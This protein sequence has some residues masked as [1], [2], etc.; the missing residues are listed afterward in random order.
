[1]TFRLVLPGLLAAA[2]AYAPPAA[3]RH[4]RDH[5]E[6]SLDSD[7]P[8]SLRYSLTPWLRAGVDLEVDVEY[9]QDL[10]LDASV[11]DDLGSIEPILSLA[12]SF[13]DGGPL[14][15]FIE[16]ELKRR[17]LIDPPDG[18]RRPP[19]RLDLKTAYLYASTPGSPLA[20][21]IGRQN[22]S[23]EREWLY[24][25]D[26]DGVRVFWSGGRFALE[27]SV[28]R[29]RLVD[30]DLL[31]AQS[32]ER[33]NNYFLVGRYAVQEDLEASAYVLARDDREVRPEDLILFG[34]RSYGELASD[35]D[36]WL[37][38]AIVRG[39]RRSRDIRGYGFDVGATYRIARTMR[40]SATLGLAFGSGD[41]NRRDGVD[42]DFRQ[43]GL[44]DNNARFNGVTS[45]GYYGE[46]L[47]PELSN[48]YIATAAFGFR[49]T[50]RSSIDLVYHYYRQHHAEDDLRDTALEVDPNGDDPHLG[51]ALDLVV[52]YREIEDMKLEL[53][54][55]A[56]F[57]GNA[58]ARDAD[59][60][61][62]G[63]FEVK[64]EL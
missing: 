6:I 41:Q 16:F 2:L 36:H 50:P 21:E 40:P 58:F 55:G 39:K 7:A 35:L 56:F 10:D 59:T 3:A 63:A 46:V 60:A 19:T 31:N 64:Y 51:Q 14:R 45:F 23:D 49:P 15:A 4:S 22:F 48:L 29:E 5:T 62:F 47:D 13:D 32:N 24:D 28:T 12:F 30:K 42:R 57:P 61:Y 18:T 44:Q 27:G 20:V 26:L 33:L 17:W 1:M 34:V 37:E 25:E 43:S 9:E 11:D 38:A 52:G 8:P 54:L 53:I